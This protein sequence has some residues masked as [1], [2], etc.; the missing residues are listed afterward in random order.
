VIL[1]HHWGH[2]DHGRT[3]ALDARRKRFQL[4]IADAR[5]HDVD[6]RRRAVDLRRHLPLQHV[7]VID[8]LKAGYPGRRGPSPDD[9]YG[10]TSE[11]REAGAIH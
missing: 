2:D 3:T 6:A 1:Q 7:A 9:A 4:L 11:A 8:A 10:A 5:H